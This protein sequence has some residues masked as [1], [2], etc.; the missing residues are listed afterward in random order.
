M[1]AAA[2][3]TNNRLRDSRCRNSLPSLPCDGTMISLSFSVSPLATRWHAADGD[4]IA[5]RRVI[6]VII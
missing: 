3:V 5:A 1:A 4:L 6:T 2:P